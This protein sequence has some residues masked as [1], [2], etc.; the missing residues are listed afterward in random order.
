VW[1]IKVFLYLVDS[2]LVLQE[3]VD[4]PDRELK[5]QSATQD[6]R[7]PK[8]DVVFGFVSWGI[9]PRTVHP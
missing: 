6:L 9:I 4:T 7:P 3:T 1:Y 8:L 2:D 5:E